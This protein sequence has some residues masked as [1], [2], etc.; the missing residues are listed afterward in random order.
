MKNLLFVLALVL[1]G[2]CK[3][4]QPSLESGAEAI[5][6]PASNHVLVF[7]KT[8]GYRHASIP[9]GIEHLRALG[10]ENDFD[11]TATEDSLFFTAGN[12]SRFQAVI[13]L[14]TTGDIL[15]DA[16]QQAMQSYVENGGG[17]VGIH[18][19]ADTEYGWPWYGELVGAYFESHP[20]IQEAEVQVLDPV[21]PSTAGLPR[22]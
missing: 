21:H 13:F 18:S 14:N 19:A 16:G 20:S 1:L 15:D 6:K 5:V 10:A 3:S 22:R 8:N 17:Y 9:T 12:L 4:T 2:S 11:V 7:S